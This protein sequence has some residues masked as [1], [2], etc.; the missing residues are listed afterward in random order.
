M[1]AGHEKGGVKDGVL[2]SQGCSPSPE[3]FLQEEVLENEAET[4]QLPY[5]ISLGL[6]SS[7]NT[8]SSLQHKGCLKPLR[9]PKP[10]S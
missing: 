6:S 7:P 9:A 3:S 4:P 8:F 1:G 5:V 10:R 2:C